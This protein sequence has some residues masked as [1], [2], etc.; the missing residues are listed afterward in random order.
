LKTNP[1]KR[2]DL[3]EFVECYNPSNR[4]ERVETWSE[5][6][7]EGRWRVFD[8]ADLMQR[9]KV[10]LDIFWLRGESLEDTDNLPEPEVLAREI[11]E[12]LEAA[13][14]QFRG[15]LEDLGEEEK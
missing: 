14:E 13:L 4:H 1:L 7:P 10:N 11:V 12:E 6:N 15:I 3:D 9:D 5:N 2:V 8:Y